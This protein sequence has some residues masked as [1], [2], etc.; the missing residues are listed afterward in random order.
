[1]GKY[2]FSHIFVLLYIFVCFMS[3]PFSSF[4]IVPA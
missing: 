4:G 3:T 1:M 2:Q